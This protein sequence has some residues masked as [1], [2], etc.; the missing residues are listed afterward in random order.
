MSDPRFSRVRARV[1]VGASVMIPAGTK[2]TLCAQG[3]KKPGDPGVE[4]RELV[5]ATAWYAEV[6]D[7]EPEVSLEQ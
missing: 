2:I 4:A 3:G 1:G 5:L 7:V 6:R